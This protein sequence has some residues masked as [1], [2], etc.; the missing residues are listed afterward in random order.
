MMFHP[1]HSFFFSK[2]LFGAGP[3]LS[4]PFPPRTPHPVLKN[5]D[6][7]VKRT[8]ELLPPSED[9]HA[10]LVAWST[11]TSALGG[12]CLQRALQSAKATS[13]R[14]GELSFGR[15]E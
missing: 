7:Q 5:S 2:I 1:I 15:T 4:R 14:S 11:A 12:T 9:G 13:E 6:R 10:R 8:T 3:F